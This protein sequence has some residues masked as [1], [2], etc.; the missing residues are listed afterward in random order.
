M[1]VPKQIA[2]I[3]IAQAGR[4]Q[5]PFPAARASDNPK[6]LKTAV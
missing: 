4:N 2:G 6:C 3:E 1:D 5:Q